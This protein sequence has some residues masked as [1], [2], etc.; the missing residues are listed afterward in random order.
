VGALDLFAA[1]MLRPAA[2]KAWSELSGSRP[3]PDA[4]APV[5]PAT[6]RQA[7]HGYRALGR[8]Q[9]RVDIAEKLL[10]E[11]HDVRGQ[12][13]NRPF[14][15]DPARAVS[16]GLTT[17]SYAR[18]LQLGGFRA[19]LPKPLAKGAHGPVRPPLWRWQPPRRDAG[20][21]PQPSPAAGNGA[22]AALAALFA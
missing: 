19:L 6:M 20:P 18:L 9:L 15:L 2:Q 4:M 21:A 7:P 14:V 5:L 11:A 22:F 12:S 3:A 16:T 8:Q 13:G 10:R 17:A 1:P